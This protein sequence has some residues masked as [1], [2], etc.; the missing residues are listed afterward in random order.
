M[1]DETF[2]LTEFD[3]DDIKLRIQ[4]VSDY[5]LDIELAHE[6]GLPPPDGDNQYAEDAEV[7]LRWANTADCEI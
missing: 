6:F 7:L 4:R 5:L 2:D 1:N 3:H